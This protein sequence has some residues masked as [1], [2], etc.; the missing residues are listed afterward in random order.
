MCVQKEPYLHQAPILSQELFSIGSKAR[1]AC[2][3]FVKARVL[4]YLKFDGPVEIDETRL[5]R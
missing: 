4:P 3:L 5:G 1:K 2:S